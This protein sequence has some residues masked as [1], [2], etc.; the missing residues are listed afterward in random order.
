M[1]LNKFSVDNTK[2][3]KTESNDATKDQNIFKEKIIQQ[4]PNSNIS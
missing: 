2:K 4:K 3:M 1:F